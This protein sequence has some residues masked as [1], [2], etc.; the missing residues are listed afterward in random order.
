MR[1]SAA[2]LCGLLLFCLPWLLS[3]VSLRLATEILYLGLLAVSFNLLFGY[4]GVLPFG[5]NATFGLGGYAFS[6]LLSRVPGLP[7]IDSF[8]I[9]ILLSAAASAIMGMICVRLKGGYFALM[10][11]AFSQFLYAGAIKW[12]GL[13]SGLDGMIVPLSSIKVLGYQ[14][15]TDD[16]RPLYLFTLGIVGATLLIGWLFTLTPLGRA[17]VLTRECEERAA[18][19]GFNVFAT[20]LTVFI[21]AGTMAGV[22]GALFA[23]L[24]G[25]MSPATLGIG[26]GGEVMFMGILGGSGFYLGP[27]LGAVGLTALTDFLSSS[28]SHPYFFI[29]ALYVLM[30]LFAPGGFAGIVH[31]LF[32]K[33][34]KLSEPHGV[35][36]G[37]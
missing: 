27:F 23:L 16:G 37:R 35:E 20:K 18:F 28:T 2:I 34:L 3:D 29:G 4:A 24:Q 10:S 7:W 5:H 12:R 15:S 26:F 14:L 21:L 1:A 31:K 22:S 33:R 8:V 11:L 13:T 30:V 32:G 25:L 36:E 9:A 19:L 6:I 17:V